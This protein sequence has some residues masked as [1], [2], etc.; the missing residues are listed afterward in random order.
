[1]PLF[2]RDFNGGTGQAL[3]DF[4]ENFVRVAGSEG[5]NL[6]AQ[7]NR[8]E[9]PSSGS[10]GV[11]ALA[12]YRRAGGP[13]GDQR[14]QAVLNP[15]AGG[16]WAAV[17]ARQQGGA[18]T[19]YLFMISADNGR[20]IH[21]RIAGGWDPIAT[22]SGGI[23]AATAYLV[24][25]VAINDEDGHVHL[26]MFVNGVSVLTYEDTAGSRLESG[27]TGL[28]GEQNG[29]SADPVTFDDY[30]D[31]SL[32]DEPE[33][34][35]AYPESVHELGNY[36][37]FG[38]AATVPERLGGETPDHTSGYRSPL[39]PQAE[40]MTVVMLNIGTPVGPGT[41]V[42]VFGGKDQAGGQ[43]I[44]QTVRLR[45]PAGAILEEDTF[46][47]VPVGPVLLELPITGQLSAGQYRVEVVSDAP[48]P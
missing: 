8:V 44:D 7:N 37:A 47:D 10:F 29:F 17:S 19:S 21:R 42:E 18:D 25:G 3:Q 9:R 14:V 39:N 30:E 45:S 1:M 2:T 41:A 4:D 20:M 6:I 31:E 40:A 23:T 46:E 38:S 27:E 36:E 12:V 16:S 28:A 22:A 33:P 15:G 5:H 32:E 24:E 11:S 13:T 43:R 34:Q 26:E 35:V 48:A